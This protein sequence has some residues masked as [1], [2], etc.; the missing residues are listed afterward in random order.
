MATVQNT[1]IKSRMNKDLDARLLANGEYR[2]AL[3]VQISRSEGEDVGALENILGNIL[4]VDINT[5]VGATIKNLE[6]IGYF[7][8]PTND[9]IYFM[10]TNYNDTSADQLS[11]FATSGSSHYIYSY[12]VVSGTVVQL[13]SGS[14]L[15]FSKTHPIHGINV[16]EDLLFW[17]DDRNQ[18]RKI[19]IASASNNPATSSTPYYTTED[20]ISVAKYYPYNPIRLYI[21][22]S[23]TTSAGGTGSTILA[24]STPNLDI[25]VGD[26]VTSNSATGS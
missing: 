11:N 17:T 24:L 3:N 23:S 22:N 20:Q 9:I 14:F 2:D 4:L 21:E 25:R 1:F 12:N 18:P 16:L 6:V 7:M 13:V 5:S 19:N 15:N 26:V 8:N 10:L